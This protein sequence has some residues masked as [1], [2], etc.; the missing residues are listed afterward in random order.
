M[1]Y[2]SKSPTPLD[3]LQFRFLGV[4]RKH[5]ISD[6]S[7]LITCTALVFIIHTMVIAY[8]IWG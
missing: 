4:N 1:R 7:V 5:T 2:K 8:L 6:I 3:E